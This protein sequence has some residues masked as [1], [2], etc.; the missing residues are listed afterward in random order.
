MII[1]SSSYNG[2]PKLKRA[3]VELEFSPEEIKEYIKCSKDPIYFIKTHCKIVN[4]DLGLINFGLWDFQEDM[5]QQ[6]ENNRYVIC[7]LPRQVGKTTTVAA[8]FMW[9]ILFNE[10]YSVAI[11][12]NKAAQA[13][14]ILSR[15]QLMYEHLP[16]FLQVGVVEWNKGSIELENG[17]KILAAATSSS[18]TRGGS[19]SAIYLDEF[20]FVPNNIQE[21]FFAAVYPTISSGKTTKVLI[22]STPNGL[23]LF[24]K[25]WIDSEEGRNNYTRISVH[26][27]DVPGRTKEWAEEQIRNTSQEQFNVEFE[28]NFIGSSMTLISGDVLRRLVHRN[29]VGNFNTIKIYKE[30]DPA[31]TYIIVADVARG[32]GGDYSAFVVFDVTQFPYQQVAV[33]RS[34]LVS[35]LIFPNFIFSAAKHYNNA[36]V[37]IETNDIGGQVADILHYDLEYEG[38]IS[39]TNSGR[40]GQVVGGGFSGGFHF[41]VRTT[42]SVKRIGCAN[43]KSLVEGD[44]LIINDYQTIYEMSR[45]SQKG[46]S[47]EAEEGH[48]DMVMCCVLFSW[49]TNQAYFKAITENDVR[50]S[51]YEKNVQ[52]IEEEMIPFGIF[53]DGN[54]PADNIE[55]APV[56]R[57]EFSW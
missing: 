27:S 43:F 6:F 33:Y 15:I 50:L 46:Q 29:P 10:N 26:W 49:L 20:A 40:D 11:L 4:V 47:Y 24:Y 35:P 51:L 45:F 31:G 56:Y 28:T 19:F 48:D 36:L 52:M 14:E 39:S 38:V 22:T 5:V 13:R 53:D 3:N 1:K 25:I 12:A 8:Y 42:K 17:S 2:N 18:A 34:N 21:E 57:N 16:R 54:E 44:Q 41:G 30:P 7:K 55:P 9:K 37:L 23:N 32:V